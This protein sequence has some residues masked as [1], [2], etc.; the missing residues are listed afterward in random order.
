MKESITI[1]KY[2]KLPEVKDFQLLRQVGLKH[3]ENLASNIW[4][5]Y[6]LH[7]PG[8]SVVRDAAVA[9]QAGRVHAMHDPTEGGLATGLWEMADAASKHLRVDCSPAILEDALVLCK[10]TG[11]DPLGA[12]ASGATSSGRVP[13]ASTRSA[14]WGPGW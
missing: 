8:I 2:R 10:A 11:L 3:I 12:I 5:D 1:K 13:K 6:N 7:D 14:R 4:T 9:A